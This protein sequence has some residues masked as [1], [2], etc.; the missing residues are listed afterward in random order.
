MFCARETLSSATLLRVVRALLGP[1]AVTARGPH[2]GYAALF[3]LKSKITPSCK[4]KIRGSI[5]FSFVQKYHGPHGVLG[6]FGAP[7]A[8]PAFCGVTDAKGPFLFTMVA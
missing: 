1:G 3:L 6:R 5:F 8:T 7:Y 2:V 4:G